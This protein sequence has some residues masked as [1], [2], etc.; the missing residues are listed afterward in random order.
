MSIASIRQ[1]LHLATTLE[2]NNI[3]VITFFA[4][5]K[6]EVL[7]Y[8]GKQNPPFSIIPDKDFEIYEKYGV[9]VSYLGMMKTMLNPFQNFKA[10][11][12]RFFSLK[13]M[14]EEP[15]MPADFLIDGSQKVYKAYYGKDYDDHIP[16][17]EILAWN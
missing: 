17:S 16:V 15:V 13:T 8:A 4:S 12:G 2:K 14:A 1:L 7:K 3:K 10:M 11:T 5:S 6:E 9:E